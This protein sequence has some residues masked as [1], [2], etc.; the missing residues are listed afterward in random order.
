[1]KCVTV[2]GYVH[3]LPLYAPS[4]PTGGYMSS[5]TPQRCMCPPVGD[6]KHEHARSRGPTASPALGAYARL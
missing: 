4:P 1:M 3:G 5:E 2:S 6:S